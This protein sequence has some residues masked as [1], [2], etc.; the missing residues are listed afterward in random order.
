[1]SVI[2][3]HRAIEIVSQSKDPKQ[4]IT[5]TVGNLEGVQVPFNYILVGTYIRPEKTAGGI[6]RPTENVQEDVWQGKVGLVLKW[7]PEAFKDD[8]EY[9][10]TVKPKINDWIVYSVGDAKSLNINGYPCRIMRDTRFML[11]VADPNII[12]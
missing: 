9:T 10:F 2:V 1:M 11:I 12:L 4:A 6:W 5:K 3:P 8:A 7:G